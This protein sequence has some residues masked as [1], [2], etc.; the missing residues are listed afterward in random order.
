ML[1]MSRVPR[2]GIDVVEITAN[3]RDRILTLDEGHFCELKAIDIAPS[4]LTKTISACAFAF[5]V[6]ASAIERVLRQNRLIHAHRP[7][8]N[9]MMG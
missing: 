3:E 4:K 1:K 6:V 7:P 8:C 2:A 9:Q 5:D